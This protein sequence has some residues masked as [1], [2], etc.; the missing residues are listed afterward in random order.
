MIYEDRMC[1][2]CRYYCAIVIVTV[3]MVVNDPNCVD[4]FWWPGHFDSCVARDRVDAG[5][6]AV[7]IVIIAVVSPIH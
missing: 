3:L 5:G 7:S 6:A 1:D 2:D 4:G